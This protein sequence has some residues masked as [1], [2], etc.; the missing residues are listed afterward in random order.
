MDGLLQSITY[1]LTSETIDSPNL[2]VT[3][4]TSASSTERRRELA[5]ELL[6]QMPAMRSIYFRVVEA[7]NDPNTALEKV[8]KLVASDPVM[9]AKVL[10]LANSAEV[11]L[12]RRLVSAEEAVFMLGGEQVKNIIVFVETF[13]MCQ[14]FALR[15]FSPE[16]LWRHSTK[17]A[18]LARAVMATQTRE[19]TTRDAAYTAGLLH[20][21]GK[22]L[23]VANASDRYGK[24]LARVQPAHSDSLILREE[25]EFEL[26]H[27]D[28]GAVA[29]ESLRIP[30]DLV[31]AVGGHH[32]AQW[33]GQSKFTSLDA[34]VV[35]NTLVHEKQQQTTG[36][37]QDN[38]IRKR[39]EELWGE[40]LFQRWLTELV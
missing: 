36:L 22:L 1:M 25:E 32:Q 24:V 30:V 34:V 19:R 31:D 3:T 16:R 9:T 14:R 38:P 2:A 17:V 13:S 23:F 15:G 8:G 21:L 7:L 26:S 37:H 12:R 39:C 5:C 35:A 27:A 10:Q 18:G 40:E 29:L 28:V 11:G 33:L 4:W 20:D 6:S